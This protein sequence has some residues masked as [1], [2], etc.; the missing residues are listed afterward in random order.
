MKRKLYYDF[1]YFFI[2]LNY[3]QKTFT[4]F[5]K[6][7]WFKLQIQNL[8][9]FFIFITHLVRCLQLEH[10]DV[11]YREW[12]SCLSSNSYRFLKRICQ[13]HSFTA[14]QGFSSAVTSD[15]KVQRCNNLR[16]WQNHVFDFTLPCS[17]WELYVWSQVSK[18]MGTSLPLCLAAALNSLRLLQ[19]V[20]EQR[21][22]Q[23]PCPV[24]LMKAMTTCQAAL[25]NIVLMENAGS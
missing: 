1:F 21:R 12:I 13:E 22:C 16:R 4:F 10:L 14:G 5:F 20:P 18:W 19:A 3:L 17:L 15:P 23:S 8:Y 9:N 24:W 6:K 11:T 7:S 25:P 2:F